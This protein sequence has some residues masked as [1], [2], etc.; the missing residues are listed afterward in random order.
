MWSDNLYYNGTSQLSLKDN[1]MIQIAEYLPP[2]PSPLWKLARQAGVDY[3][4]GG[5]PVGEPFNGQAPD[6]A[7]VEQLVAEGAL[8]G[9]FPA[10]SRRYLRQP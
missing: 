3:V 7:A 1:T 5:L 10:L 9:E 4:V 6:L 8:V 2:T